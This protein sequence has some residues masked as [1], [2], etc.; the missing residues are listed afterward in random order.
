MLS[1]RHLE[2][3]SAAIVIRSLAEVVTRVDGAGVAYLRLRIVVSGKW[4]G[5]LNL[6]V[7]DVCTES[8][9]GRITFVAEPPQ[10]SLR[11]IRQ[12]GLG[13]SNFVDHRSSIA[14]VKAPRSMAS[15]VTGSPRAVDD[16]KKYQ[17][18]STPDA[19]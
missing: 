16:L 5:E 4:A 17:I 11:E 2:W 13:S 18:I 7:V 10:K 8:M 6:R 3:L 12:C 15:P 14:R 1:V 9:F 19:L